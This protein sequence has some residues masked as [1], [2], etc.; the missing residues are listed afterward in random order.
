MIKKLPKYLS[1]DEIQELFI[2]AHSE[3]IML[4]MLTDLVTLFGDIMIYKKEIYIMK[5]K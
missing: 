2:Y 1:N 5:T 4:I 3:K